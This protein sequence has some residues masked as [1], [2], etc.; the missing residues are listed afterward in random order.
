MSSDEPAAKRGLMLTTRI[1]KPLPT[2]RNRCFLH[3]CR[4][5]AAVAPSFKWT[6][7]QAEARYV[8]FEVARRRS[9]RGAPRRPFHLFSSPSLSLTSTWR[10]WKESLTLHDFNRPT[11]HL[12]PRSTRQARVDSAW[13]VEHPHAPRLLPRVI[14]MV[15]PCLVTRLYRVPLACVAAKAPSTFTGCHRIP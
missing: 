2:R 11:T 10:A 7:P 15:V 12:S 5:A 3:L 6:H 13:T 4:Q 8:P 1:P 14:I 9:Q